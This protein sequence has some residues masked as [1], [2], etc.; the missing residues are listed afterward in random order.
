M[1]T[2]PPEDRRVPTDDELRELLARG[3]AELAEADDRRLTT[4]WRRVSDE[5]DAE[6]TAPV[7][8]AT[9]D[10]SVG[11]RTEPS[12]LDERRERRRRRGGGAGRWARFAPMAA[13]ASLA[14]VVGVGAGATLFD[15]GDAPTT[16]TLATYELEPLGDE[17]ASPVTAQLREEDGVTT[18]EVDLSTLSSA[19]GGYLEVWLLDPDTGALASLG[20]ARPDN[21]YIVPSGTEVD[22]LTALDVSAEPLDGD[23]A[24]S[25]DSLLRGEITWTG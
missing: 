24:H 21:R 10:H 7:T 18:V 5:L 16:A 15:D 14:L 3:L 19:D 23:P 1:T 4:T 13:A 22:V 12:S 6:G 11:P 25:G 8:A 2:H 17:G 20:P 9:R